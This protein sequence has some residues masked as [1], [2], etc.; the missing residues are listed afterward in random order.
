MHINLKGDKDFGH[1]CI[2][3]PLY[4]C[5]CIQHTLSHTH[6]HWNGNIYIY[7]WI[8]RAG[9][10]WPLPIYEWDLCSILITK[11]KKNEE[12]SQEDNLRNNKCEM[13]GIVTLPIVI[14]I[15]HLYVHMFVLAC[16][17]HGYACVYV[18][19]Y[20]ACIHHVIY[21]PMNLMWRLGLRNEQK[22]HP[23]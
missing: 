20:V 16:N 1:T 5:T 11:K 9:V 21:M 13:L 23:L 6:T 22:Q 14:S 15:L 4:S 7:K 17:M 8:Q 18:C 3:M 10:I 2:H 12:N 19:I